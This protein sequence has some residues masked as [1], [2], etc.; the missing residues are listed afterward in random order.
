MDEKA[1]EYAPMR[2]AARDFEE[3]VKNVERD[4]EI[5]LFF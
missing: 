5:L 4:N 3:R 1:M 2:K